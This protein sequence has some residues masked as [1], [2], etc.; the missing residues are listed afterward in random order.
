MSIKQ[1]ENAL[2]GT[3]TWNAWRDKIKGMYNNPT[4]VHLNSVFRYWNTQTD[5]QTVSPP[6]EF[7]D[8]PPVN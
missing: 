4:E 5:N 7:E 3:L 8:T 6:I 2:V 1:I